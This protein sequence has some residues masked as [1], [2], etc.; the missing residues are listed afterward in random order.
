M[1]SDGRHENDE[2]LTSN[3]EIFRSY[4]IPDITI[5]KIYKSP[6]LKRV[7][8]TARTPLNFKNIISAR[9]NQYQIIQFVNYFKS[10][11]LQIR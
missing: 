6:L 5:S 1:E 3:P 10:L 2:K 9:V 8:Y 7:I 11:E 4:K